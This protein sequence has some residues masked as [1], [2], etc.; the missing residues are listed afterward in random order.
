MQTIKLDADSPLA[1]AIKGAH[2]S[3][4]FVSIQTAQ[5]EKLYRGVVDNWT[6]REGVCGVIGQELTV[7][8]KD[9]DAYW[10]EH[11]ARKFWI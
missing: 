10:G 6:V 3:N 1:K 5:G 11:A 8:L 9:W 4:V 2:A 7:G